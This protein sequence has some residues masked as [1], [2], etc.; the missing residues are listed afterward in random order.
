MNRFSCGLAISFI[1]VVA[2]AVM[3][4]NSQLDV[5]NFGAR[6]NRNPSINTGTDATA[7]PL[8][9]DGTDSVSVVVE[10]NSV[11]YSTPH[12]YADCI[13]GRSIPDLKIKNNDSG[14]HNLTTTDNTVNP[15]TPGHEHLEP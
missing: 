3:A 6:S 2:Y 13:V 4:P 8:A 14:C 5:R 15:T 10:E 11:V 7:A 9:A 1:A 12:S